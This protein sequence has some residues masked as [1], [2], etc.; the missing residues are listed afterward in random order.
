MID[1][2]VISFSILLPIVIYFSN[3]R[4]ISGTGFEIVN[5]FVHL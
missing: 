3:F 4:F 1:L 2:I 5:I